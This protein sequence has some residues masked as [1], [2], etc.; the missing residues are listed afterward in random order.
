MTEKQFTYIPTGFDSLDNLLPN[1]EENKPGGIRMFPGAGF[2]GVIFGAASA[3]KSVLTLQLACSFLKKAFSAWK[4]EMR[5]LFDAGAVRSHKRTR[6][7]VQ[8]QGG[9]RCL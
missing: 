5:G 3:G 4:A 9:F 6:S 1:S 2:L 8:I 7:G